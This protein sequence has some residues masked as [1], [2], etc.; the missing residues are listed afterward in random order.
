M[1]V[2][3][4]K[5]IGNGTGGGYAIILMDDKQLRI[6]SNQRHEEGERAMEKMVGKELCLL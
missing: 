2:W 1:G 6:F 4:F 5:Y 3:S